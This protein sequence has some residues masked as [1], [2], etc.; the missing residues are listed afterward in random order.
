MGDHGGVED[1]HILDIGLVRVV[2]PC[3]LRILESRKHR[4]H[5]LIHHNLWGLMM[6]V[7]PGGVPSLSLF[8]LVRRDRYTLHMERRVRD[9]LLLTLTLALISRGSA[10]AIN[11]T[12]ID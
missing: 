2:I 5:V 11:E 4:V 1:I 8:G 12:I 10:W 6:Q 3:F 7:T 9:R